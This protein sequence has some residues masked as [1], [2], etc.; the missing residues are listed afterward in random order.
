MKAYSQSSG[1]AE[2]ALSSVKVVHTYGQE[3]LEEKIYCK[4]LLRSKNMANKTGWKQAMVSGI[5]MSC[6]F[7]FYAYC[8]YF[9]G[10]LR[11]EEIENSKVFAEEGKKSIYTGGVVITCLFCLIMAVV[12]VATIGQYMKH[13]NDA[14]VAGRMAFDIIDHVP[15][16]NPN[17]PGAPINKETLRG[18]YRFDR[19]NFSYPSNKIQ[20]LKDFTC[21]FEAGKTTAFVGPS[22]SGKST[23]IQLV[24]RFY[25][26]DNGLITLDG[27]PLDH[28][29]LRGMRRA[30]GY[31]GQEPVLF[32]TTI[33]ENMRLAKP[34]ATEIE[35]VEALK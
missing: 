19:V 13:V 21:T 32:N 14:K 12:R 6:F 28:Y 24:E 16:V 22:G 35:M 31:V 3:L 30:I 2:Q 33:R 1:L 34:D 25:N 4:Y 17:S 9:G 18:E 29:D 26:P 20:V 23:I 11:S 27:V 8:F 7:F 5:L 10:Y 15:D